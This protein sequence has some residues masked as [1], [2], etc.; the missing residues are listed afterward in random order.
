MRPP[1]LRAKSGAKILILLSVHG[2]TL[3]QPFDAT[4]KVKTLS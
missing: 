1:E 4:A 3:R 2:I